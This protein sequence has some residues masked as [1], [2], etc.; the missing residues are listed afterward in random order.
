MGNRAYG[1]TVSLLMESQAGRARRSSRLRAVSRSAQFVSIQ[2]PIAHHT[3]CTVFGYWH[4]FVSSTRLP[5]L[6]SLRNKVVNAQCSPGMAVVNLALEVLSTLAQGGH[7]LFVSCLILI[8]SEAPSLHAI[9]RQAS[10]F[11]SPQNP[12]LALSSFRKN[13]LA[14]LSPACCS[15][16]LRPFQHFHIPIAVLIFPSLIA[17]CL[18][19]VR[20]RR[21]TEQKIKSQSIDIRQEYFL[22]LIYYSGT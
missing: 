13:F 4:E 22:L 15:L 9:K 8:L 2:I 3:F 18:I 16:C 10:P 6:P 7:T 17:P 19:P 12:V 1:W 14:T 11:S 21:T 20:I 5:L